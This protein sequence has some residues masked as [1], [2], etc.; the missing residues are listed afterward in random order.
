MCP[1]RAIVNLLQPASTLCDVGPACVP[2]ELLS[3]YF[4]LPQPSVMLIQCVYY[5]ADICKY[6]SGKIIL[7]K[8]DTDT[9]RLDTEIVDKNISTCCAYYLNNTSR[10]TTQPDRIS[11]LIAGGNRERNNSWERGRGGGGEVTRNKI[12]WKKVSHIGI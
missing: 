4:N 12:C 1:H 2:I 6:K 10:I 7:E 9:T 5:K 8:R 3:T 11:Q